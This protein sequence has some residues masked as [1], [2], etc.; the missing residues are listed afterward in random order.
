MAKSRKGLHKEIASIFDGVPITK[1][2]GLGQPPYAPAPE[3]TGFQKRPDFKK[4]PAGAAVAS[5]PPTPG[6]TTPRHSEPAPKV[7]PS[8]PPQ[9]PPVTSITGQTLWQQTLDRISNRLFAQKPGVN[10]GRRKVL[11]MLAPLLIIVLIFV[12]MKVLMP[13]VRGT[14]GDPT[15]E[16]PNVVAAAGGKIDWQI[17][18][19]YPVTL[20][21]PMQF[22]KGT[23]QTGPGQENPGQLIVKGTVYSDADPLA[24]IGTQIVH[25]GD[26]VSGATIVKINKSSVEFEMNGKRWTQKVQ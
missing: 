9:A 4:E 18:V 5:R 14:Q 11:V 26:Q 15:P 1:G 10:L 2:D 19:P 16:P 20:R 25:E 21:D 23:T 7:V 17:P 22:Y 6:P 8:E 12:L 3:R 24:V 13:P